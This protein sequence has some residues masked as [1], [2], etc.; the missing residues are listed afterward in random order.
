MIKTLTLVVAA[1]AIG[2]LVATPA[3]AAKPGG[4]NAASSKAVFS[5]SPGVSF[6]PFVAPGGDFSGTLPSC[7]GDAE[8]DEPND[9][10]CTGW[11]TLFDLEGAI[12]TSSTGALEAVVS[13]ECSLWTDSEGSALIG[14]TGSGGSRAGVEI[15]VFIDPTGDGTTGLMDPGHIVYCDRLQ[16]VEV[17]IPVLCTGAFNN[18]GSCTVPVVSNDPFVV[19]LFQRTKN[20]HAY[21]FY[22]PTP[23][24]DVHDI[25]VEARGIIQCFKDG[26][27]TNCSNAS[28]DIDKVI[29]SG[30][31]S[32]TDLTGGT[33]AVI[34]TSTLV[35]EEHQ[36]WRIM[37]D[38]V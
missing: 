14:A 22:L 10:L 38:G 33:K 36:N 4:G 7:G 6:M 1:A 9:K 16:Y 29:G 18:D 3:F 25:L 21:H 2:A 32:G 12:K 27:S 35:I 17:T 8:F 23:A 37:D 30:D 11:K 26:V 24:T 19:R 34:G 5:N 15:R 28:I 31:G 13:V 20:A